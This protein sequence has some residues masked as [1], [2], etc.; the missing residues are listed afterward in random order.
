MWVI[1][2]T[3]CDY[4]APDA[5]PICVTADE[6]MANDTVRLLNLYVEFTKNRDET[7]A[8]QMRA[9]WDAENP[10]PKMPDY[11]GSDRLY[12]GYEALP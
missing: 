1:M 7:V 12:G 2:E 8:A 11:P 10:S 5:I 4:D 6:E 9:G 3:Y